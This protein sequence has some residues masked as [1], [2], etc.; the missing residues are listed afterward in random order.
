VQITSDSG[1]CL[2]TMARNISSGGLGL[3]CVQPPLKV[4]DMLTATF[5]LPGVEQFVAVRAAVVW[6]QPNGTAGIRFI[7]LKAGTAELLHDWIAGK[8]NL[9]QA[10]KILLPPIPPERIL[11]VN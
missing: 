10:E 1:L 2:V 5:T 4:D 9:L 3:Q 6:S 8:H 11:V 7:E